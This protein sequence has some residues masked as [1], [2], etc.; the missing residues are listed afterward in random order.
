MLFGLFLMMR[1]TR[2]SIFDRKFHFAATN[3]SDVVRNKALLATNPYSKT[4]ILSLAKNR[5]HDIF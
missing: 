3:H 5:K 4:E 1:D 2:R